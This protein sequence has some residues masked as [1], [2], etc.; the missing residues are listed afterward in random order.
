MVRIRDLI[1]CLFSEQPHPAIAQNLVS[2]ER[3]S[4]RA[5]I[6][7]NDLLLAAKVAER[8]A[9]VGEHQITR[10]RAEC[11]GTL[12]PAAG[13]RRRPA[14]GG[15]IAGFSVLLKFGVLAIP[16]SAFWSGFSLGLLYSRSFIVIQLAHATLANKHP[17]TTAMTIRAALGAAGRRSPSHRHQLQHA[18]QRDVRGEDGDMLGNVLVMAPTEL[19]LYFLLRA[20]IGARLRRHPA[21]FP[22]PPT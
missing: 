4:I 1:D 10:D 20:A 13:G 11:R 18:A 7:N 22:L 5:L 8:G 15:F 12:L 16:L 19:L 2:G 21:S 14:S 17:A 3:Y 9:E 6:A